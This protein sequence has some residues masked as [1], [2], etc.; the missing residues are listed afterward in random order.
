M[1]EQDRKLLIDHEHRLNQHNDRIE[2]LHETV[3]GSGDYPGLRIL[4]DRL[5]QSRLSE[6]DRRA[7]YTWPLVCVLA[8]AITQGIVAWLVR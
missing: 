6:Q 5:M 4:V 7:L 3:H 1:D 2:D 8:G